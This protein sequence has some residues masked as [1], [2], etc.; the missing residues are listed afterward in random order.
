MKVFLSESEISTQNATY[1]WPRK[2]SHYQI[3]TWLNSNLF[4][5][6]GYCHRELNGY[7]AHNVIWITI[8]NLNSHC[9][10]SSEM[11]LKINST[12]ESV[13]VSLK[14]QEEEWPH[15]VSIQGLLHVNRKCLPK[16]I[17]HKY[18]PYEWETTN[19]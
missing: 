3:T 18:L 13:S 6:K 14:G 10:K 19:K 5:K 15:I 7:G 8:T 11:E 17:K 4:V 9:G 12:N 2:C 16:V 1:T